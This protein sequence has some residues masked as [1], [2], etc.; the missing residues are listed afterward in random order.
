MNIPQCHVYS[1][2]QIPFSRLI[3]T[4][5]LSNSFVVR[6]V[7]VM[8]SSYAKIWCMKGLIHVCFLKV[9]EDSSFQLPPE[10]RFSELLYIPQKPR[11]VLQTSLREVSQALFSLY[12]MYVCISSNN[13]YLEMF[14]VCYTKKGLCI[15]QCHV[16]WGAL[17]QDWNQKRKNLIFLI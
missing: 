17:F 7:S 14:L 1:C 12:F 9:W 11:S 13:W 5:L 8:L 2:S 15:K 10:K 3:S 4:D 16:R 6:L